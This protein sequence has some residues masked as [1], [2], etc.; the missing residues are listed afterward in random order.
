MSSSAVRVERQRGG[1]CT[2]PGR[3]AFPVKVRRIARGHLDARAAWKDRIL[4]STATAEQQVFHTIYLIKLRR[5]HVPIE[6]DDLQVLRVG[7]DDLAGV[8]R[9]RD[10]THAGAAEGWGVEGDED[11]AGTGRLGPI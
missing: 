10:G 5:V 1:S 8:L 3:L 11:L 7:R 9:L 4:L 2:P 6:H